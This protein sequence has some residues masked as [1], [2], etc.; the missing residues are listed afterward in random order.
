MGDALVICGGGSVAA[1]LPDLDDPF[2]VA[3]D[4]GAE[5][6]RRLGYRIDV[7]IGD[8]DS[9]RASDLAEVT[10]GEGLVERH[11]WDKDETDLELAIGRA[12]A[13]GATR[14]VVAGGD[15]GRLDMILANALLLASPRWAEVEIDAVFGGARLTV[16]RTRRGL[17]GPPGATVSLFA[18]GGPAHGVRTEGLRWA[19]DGETL[20]PGST[21]GLSNEFGDTGEATVSVEDGVVVAVQP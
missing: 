4:G 15:D 2:V 17:A 21:R 20:E 7:L 18:L 3:A 11:P 13:E 6:A 1:P 14:V 10:W 8:M 9:V 16:V 19:L 5:E 12:V